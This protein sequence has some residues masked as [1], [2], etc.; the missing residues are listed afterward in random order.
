MKAFD[1]FMILFSSLAI[2]AGLIALLFLLTDLERVS[3]EFNFTMVV[4]ALVYFSA[5]GWGIWLG[6]RNLKESK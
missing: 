3:K 6:L 2:F 4:G 5:F 1:W